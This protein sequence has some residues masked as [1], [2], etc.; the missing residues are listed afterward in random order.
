MEWPMVS[1]YRPL[2]LTMNSID[3]LILLLSPEL[4]VF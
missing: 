4:S 3:A 1:D 2:A